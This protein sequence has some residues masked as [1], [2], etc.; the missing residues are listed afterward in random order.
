[1]NVNEN[2]KEQLE[3]IAGVLIKTF[4]A[5]LIILVIWVIFSIFG[6]E[7]AFR[8]QEEMFGIAAGQLMVI[9]YAG[10][11]LFKLFLFSFFLL[12][13]IGIHWKIKCKCHR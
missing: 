4:V 13:Y 2:T 8:I 12:P 5:G 3:L 6:A 10:M 1:M 11:G 7:A 9:N